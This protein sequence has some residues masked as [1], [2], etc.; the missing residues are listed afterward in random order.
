VNEEK[1][2]LPHLYLFDTFKY[3]LEQAKIDALP[4]P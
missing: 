4:T 2:K 3:N 1:P